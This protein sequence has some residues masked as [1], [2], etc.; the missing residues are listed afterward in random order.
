MVAGDG[1]IVFPEASLISFLPSSQADVVFWEAEERFVRVVVAFSL[2]V[3]LPCCPLLQ[4]FPVLPWQFQLPPG[5]PADPSAAAQML[6]VSLDF[7]FSL[8]F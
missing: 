4:P 1:G 7:L 8:P 6:V 2:P 5:P 3:L